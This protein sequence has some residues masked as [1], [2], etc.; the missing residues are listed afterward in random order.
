MASPHVAGVVALMAQK[1]PALG[2]AEAEQILTSTATPLPAGCRDIVEP[3]GP[4]H[5]CWGSDATGA[6]LVTADAALGAIP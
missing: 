2:Q 1:K 3:A 6:G 5:V 4:A